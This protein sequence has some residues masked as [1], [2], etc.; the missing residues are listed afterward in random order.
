MSIITLEVQACCHLVWVYCCCGLSIELSSLNNRVYTS[1]QFRFRKPRHLGGFPPLDM[2]QNVGYTLPETNSKSPWKWMVGIRSFPFGF[3]PIFRGELLVSG[4]VT[5]GFQPS[6]TLQAEKSQRFPTNLAV[7]NFSVQT[8]R[9]S[10]FNSNVIVFYRLRASAKVQIA[11]S[12]KRKLMILIYLFLFLYYFHVQHR[13]RLL[14]FFRFPKTN[15]S[16]FHPL[17]GVV[18]PWRT[19]SGCHSGL[20]LPQSLPSLKLTWHSTWKWMVGIRSFPFGMAYFQGRTVSF[21][22]GIKSLKRQL[23]PVKV[24]HHFLDLLVR[25]LENKNKNIPQ[26][27][28]K[29]DDLP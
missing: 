21:R 5:L 3:R 19:K 9:C 20:T 17:F 18:H 8:N 10:I 13:D 26:M 27:V 22:E 1:A 2:K 12:W 28:V 7:R 4:R 23:H 16:S 15:L 14:W 6:Q 24:N 29:N 25:C 11:Y